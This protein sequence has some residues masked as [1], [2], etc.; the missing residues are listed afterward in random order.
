MRKLLLILLTLGALFLTGGALADELTVG[1]GQPNVFADAGMSGV[2]YTSDDPAVA[3]V[4]AISGYISAYRPGTCAIRAEKEGKTVYTL[5]LTVLKAPTKLSVAEKNVEMMLGSQR[6]VQSCTAPEGEYCDQLEIRVSGPAVRLTDGRLLARDVGT[7]TVYLR[8]YN[9]AYASYEVK[10]RVQPTAVN[11]NEHIVHLGIGEEFVPSVQLEPAFCY[12]RLRWSVAGDAQAVRFD[13]ASLR[14]QAI[15]LGQ[16]VITVTTENGLSDSLT[17]AVLPLPE[18]LNEP[19]TVFAAQGEAGKI[20][21]VLPEGT[22]AVLTYESLTPKVLSVSADGSWTALGYGQAEVR[23]SAQDT[24]LTVTQRF[25][26]APQ[27]AA[28]EVRAEEEQLYIGKSSYCRATVQPEGSYAKVTWASSNPGCVAVDADGKITA[29]ALGSAVISATAVSGAKGR[30]TV[31][32]LKSPQSISLDKSFL[33]LEKGSAAKLNCIFPKDTLC[34]V[35]FASLDASVAAVDPQSGE[36]IAAGP[37]STAVVATT[38]NGLVASCFVTVPYEEAPAETELEILF[39]DCDSNDA[40]LLRSGDEYAF[41]DSG[42]HIYGEK[43]LAI[44]KDLGITH[45]K[46][47]IGTH[48]HLDH[49]GGAC[50]LLDNLDVDMVIVPHTR[51]I[52]AI[53]GSVWTEGERKAANE[54]LYCVIS[55]GQTFYLG[56]VPFKCIGPITVRNVD[57]KDHAENSNSLVLRADA[58]EV[59]VLLTGDGTV[60]EFKDIAQVYPEELKVDVFK[61]THHSGELSDEQIRM[62]APKITVFSTSSL[63]IPAERYLNLFRSLGSEI[64]MTPT[65][66]NGHVTLYTDGKTITVT[67]QYEDNR[68][69]W[70]NEITGKPR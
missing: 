59:S 19:E 7:A 52:Q 34:E 45:L 17:V 1:V 21:S 40:I 5:N 66:I 62:I 3:T 6:E 27:P 67:P 37:G 44:L 32:V 42:N 51:V 58:G 29:K 60:S 50:V 65:R 25:E 33:S 13:E 53:K 48:A 69:N 35:S 70:Y 43:A 23:I 26:I 38:S 54:A 61:N 36:I 56:S 49:I 68:G 39:T 15:S 12:S 63:H 46:Y 64:Y 10:V 55:H 9:G 47:Y 18:S 11:L 41:I 14:V 28:V 2:S 16:A 4:N 22:F 20:A 24:P 31:R 8:A 30:V 57:T